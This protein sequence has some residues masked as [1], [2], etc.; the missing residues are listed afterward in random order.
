MSA[1][2]RVL[3]QRLKAVF[4]ERGITDRAPDIVYEFKCI[5]LGRGGERNG[6]YNGQE[7]AIRKH[8]H[9]AHFLSISASVACTMPSAASPRSTKARAERT[10]SA[11]TRRFSTSFQT[12]SFVSASRAQRPTGT[13]SGSPVV[14]RS[15]PNFSASVKW[16]P[17]FQPKRHTKSVDFPHARFPVDGRRFNLARRGL[18]SSS[19][20]RRIRR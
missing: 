14:K 6:I 10:L 19:P 5:R 13:E 11:R 12:P 1:L 17:I 15:P 16:G 3:V 18:P 7:S 9:Q 20:Q 4:L 2:Q 8:I